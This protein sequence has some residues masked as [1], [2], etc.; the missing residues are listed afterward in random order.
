MINVQV[1]ILKIKTAI[2]VEQN[3]TTTKAGFL[4]INSLLSKPVHASDLVTDHKLH[5]LSLKPGSKE[6][7][8]SPWMKTLRQLI[9]IILSLEKLQGEGVAS[10]YN[11]SVV[12][13]FRTKTNKKSF[14]SLISNIMTPTGKHRSKFDMSLYVDSRPTLWIS[15]WIVRLS[16]YF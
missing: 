8:I 1:F 14:G 7:K 13:C 5:F 15:V 4:N 12:I 9:F 16:L 6:T 10:N 3:P 2:V 11:T